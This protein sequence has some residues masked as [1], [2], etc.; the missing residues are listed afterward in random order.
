MA[1]EFEITIAIIF[2][3]GHLVLGF[4]LE[5]KMRGIF[6]I[7]SGCTSIYLATILPLS[8]IFVIPLCVPVGLILILYGVYI[9]YFKDKTKK[10]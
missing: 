7:I 2:Y 3:F 4:S 6:I 8:P 9:M 5:D 10:G 1:T